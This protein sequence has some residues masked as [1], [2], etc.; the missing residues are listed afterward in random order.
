MTI[1]PANT[2]SGPG[3]EAIADALKKN[4]EAAAAVEDV[5]DQLGVVHAVLRTKIAE[6]S[7]DADADTE[8]AVERT[9]QLE[10][11]LHE[12]AEKMDEVNQAIEAQHASLAHLTKAN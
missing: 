12:T 11:K 2:D 6:S 3:A 1:T 9:H 10:E 7:A 8:A 4:I 5:A